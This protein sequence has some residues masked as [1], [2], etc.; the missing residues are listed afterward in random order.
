MLGFVKGAEANGE[1]KVN[2][3]SLDAVDV[4]VQKE[5]LLRAGYNEFYEVNLESPEFTLSDK[6]YDAT[7]L[8]EPEVLIKKLI[9]NLKPGGIK[10]GGFPSLP[11]YMEA[12]RKAKIRQT[13]RK[14]GHVSVFSPECVRKMASDNGLEVELLSGAFLMRKKA[15]SWKTINGGL[16]SFYG[17]AGCFL[18]CHVK[19]IGCCVS[20]S[21]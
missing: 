1:E 2:F 5:L 21:R 7:I 19:L 10:I 20:P 8:F 3:A 4:I 14:Y 6:N 13:A 18:P 9:K 12:K 11:K 15:F 17:L 16:N